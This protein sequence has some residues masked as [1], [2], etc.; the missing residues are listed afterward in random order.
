MPDM[1]LSPQLTVPSP[2]VDRLEDKK[3]RTPPEDGIEDQARHWLPFPFPIL[4]LSP[5]SGSR[6]PTLACWIPL[7]QT[8]SVYCKRLIEQ[9][10]DNL[11]SEPLHPGAALALGEVNHGRD[12]LEVADSGARRGCV[13]LDF[14]V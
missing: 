9:A 8:R 2:T 5:T 11:V 4:Y 1:H 3:R 12:G 7:Y 10:F 6:I 13:Q 14:Q